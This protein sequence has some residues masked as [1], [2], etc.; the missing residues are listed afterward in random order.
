M[1]QYIKSASNTARRAHAP[2]AQQVVY[3]WQSEYGWCWLLAG[4]LELSLKA[5]SHLQLLTNSSD[6]C[7]AVLEWCALS[8]VPLTPR[9]RL[10]QGKKLFLDIEN[11]SVI[12]ACPSQTHMT[13]QRVS[14]ITPCVSSVSAGT[15]LF[16]VEEAVHVD[17]KKG[18]PIHLSCLVCVTTAAV[19]VGIIR[20]HGELPPQH[21]SVALASL[22]P[23]PRRLSQT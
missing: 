6:R 13:R 19:A 14:Y 20:S 23:Y 16:G 22:L 21:N 12:I 7:T 15:Q 4:C 2:A 8:S 9:R 10:S 3:S 18:K 11:R 1:G 5:S 17:R